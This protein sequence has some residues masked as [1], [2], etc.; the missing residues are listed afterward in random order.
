MTPPS[1]SEDD[2]ATETDAPA[3]EPT[4]SGTSGSGATGTTPPSTQ[5]GPSP[6]ASASTSEWSDTWS[7]DQRY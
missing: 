1:V 5:T 6:S 4:V 2:T 3:L 7:D